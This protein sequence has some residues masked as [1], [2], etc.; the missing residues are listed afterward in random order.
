MAKKAKVKT[1]RAALVVKKGD[2]ENFREADSPRFEAAYTRLPPEFSGEL[3]VVSWN[4]MFSQEIDAAITELSSEAELSGADIILLQEMDDKGVNAIAASLEYNY[5]YFPASVH[6]RTG[7]K[8]GNAVLARWPITGSR[9]LL[10]PNASPRTGE[11]RIATRA[12]ID[13]NGH[14]VLTYSVHTETYALAVEKRHEQFRALV[15]DIE[16]E[17]NQHVLVGG[18]FNTLT[19]RNIGRLE[20]RFARVGLERARLSAKATLKP[21]MLGIS[22]DHIF[23]R[24]LKPIESGAWRQTK[25]SDHYPVWQKLSLDSCEE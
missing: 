19:A 9:K 24:G 1:S 6:C 10:L 12:H 20:Q 7:R 15:D 11:I 3:K 5:V 4:I 8:F 22:A 14:D 17:T 13:I 2:T 16:G 21:G 23:T 25:A 18:D